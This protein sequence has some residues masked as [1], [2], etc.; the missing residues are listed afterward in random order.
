M[1]IV[2]S[3]SLFHPSASRAFSLSRQWREVPQE[4]TR[5]LVTPGVD[6]EVLLMIS[7]SIPPLTRRQDFCGDATLPPL[8]VDFLGYLLCNLL[9]FG[10]VVK[11][12]ATVL[13][14]DIRTL[15]I[16]GGWVVHL[17]EEFE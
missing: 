2:L 3:H 9:L 7:L 11:N 1:S 10:V 14:A 4:M 6:V 15:A 16:L 5:A 12:C 8:L 13:C 17:I